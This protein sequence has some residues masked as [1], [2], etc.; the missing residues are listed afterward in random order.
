MYVRRPRDQLHPPA[1]ARLRIVILFQIK[2]CGITSVKDARF[3]SLAGA[4]AIGLNFYDKS[5]RHIDLAAAE[6]VILA[7]PKSV[8]KVGV[9]VN[10]PAEEINEIADRLN[11]DYVQL[12]GDEPPEV[13]GSISQRKVI[14]AFRCGEEGF[15]SISDYL[16]TCQ[17]L[18]RLPDAVLLDAHQPGEYG[19]TG[20]AIDWTSVAKSRQILGTAPLLLAGGLTPFNVAEAI[21]VAHPDAVDVASGVESSPRAKDL[22]LMR[23]FCSTAKKAFAQDAGCG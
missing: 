17:T 11:L 4:D 12:H 20:Q 9:F 8:T 3:A 5:P 10:A 14:R 7:I 18:G 1:L 13:L 19:G 16:E 22:L 23:A 6:P 15:T 21:S 2:I